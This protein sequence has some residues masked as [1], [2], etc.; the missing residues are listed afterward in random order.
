[1]FIDPEA[2]SGPVSWNSAKQSVNSAA[3]TGSYSI[4]IS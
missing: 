2:I 3:H 1:L 4:H